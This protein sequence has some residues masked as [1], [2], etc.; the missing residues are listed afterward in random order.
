M[1]PYRSQEELAEFELRFSRYR[2]LLFYIAGHILGDREAA[3]Q[4]VRG[5]WLAASCNPTPLEREG[6]FRSWLA[7]ILIDE[8]LLLRRDRPSAA[9]GKMVFDHMAE[10]RNA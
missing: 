6:A 3:K 10:L 8:A 2:A 7:R 5:C 4:A 1:D 9:A